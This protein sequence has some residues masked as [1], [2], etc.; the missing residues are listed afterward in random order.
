MYKAKMTYP[1]S[2]RAMV[3]PDCFRFKK[4][5]NMYAENA[6]LSI[7]CDFIIYIKKIWLSCKNGVLW[8]LLVRL[9]NKDSQVCYR[10][11]DLVTQISLYCTAAVLDWKQQMYHL[12]TWM[13]S[14][15]SFFVHP[16][17]T[18]QTTPSLHCLP[19][20]L[21]TMPSH[22]IMCLGR[23]TLHHLWSMNTTALMSITTE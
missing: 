4:K 22:V 21:V 13:A 6:A 19:T 11:H 5:G 23:R 18:S 14:S 12:E 15:L 17:L 3:S 20:P 2:L 16:G 10:K 9:E 7:W 8:Y 1:W